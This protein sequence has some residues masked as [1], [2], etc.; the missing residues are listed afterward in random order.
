M[1]DVLGIILGG[2]KGTRLFP[3]TLVRS[4]PAVPLAGKYRLIDIPISNCINSDLNKIFVLTQYNSESLNRHVTQ[5]YR[6]SLFSQG[7]V[8]VL[9]AEQTPESSHWFRG[10]ADAVRRSLRHILPYKVNYVL[11][12]SGDHLYRMDYREVLKY[13]QEQKAEVTVCGN[14]VEVEKASSYGILKLEDDGRISAFYEKPKDAR[15][16][17]GL[18]ISSTVRKKFGASS[19]RPLMASMGLYL[20]RTQ[21][22][23][24]VLQDENKIDFGRDIIPA[25]LSDYLVY[26]YIFSGYWED[27][28]T[29][30]AFYKAN[31]DLLSENPNFNLLDL[32][33]PLYT[34]ARFLP[35]SRVCN[36]RIRKSMISEGCLILDSKISNSIIGIRS[37]IREKA[38]IVNTLMM[39][40]DLYDT[41]SDQPI[42]LGVG[43]GSSIKN[44]IID[45]NARIGEGVQICNAS[46]IQELDAENYYIRDG[47]VI[48]PKNAVIEDGTVI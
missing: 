40:T 3:L 34:H 45:K 15:T 11:V 18:K 25:A 4:K 5:T 14:P 36:C 33:Y 8:D 44:A 20:F 22:L 10:T 48:I 7:F 27:I 21:V 37:V 35:P 39:G 13:H 28:G 38:E 16:L 42:P 9:A 23:L 47:I 17:E 6:F 46:G 24:D 12:L 2:G 29:V 31:L 1:K 26:G 43:R 32:E 41:D 30:E 19:K